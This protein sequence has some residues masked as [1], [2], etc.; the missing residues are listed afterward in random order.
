[1][2]VHNVEDFKL[3]SSGNVVFRNGD[4]VLVRGIEQF[5]QTLELW[6][7]AYHSLVIGTTMS[8]ENTKDALKLQAERVAQDSDEVDRIESF[9]AREINPREYELEIVF[10]ASEKYHTLLTEV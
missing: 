3:D 2:S 6:L 10:S 4:L 1:M 7:Q 9:K 5:K 8:K